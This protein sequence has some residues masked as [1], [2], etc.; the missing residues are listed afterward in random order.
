M[1]GK[2]VRRKK[3]NINNHNI[4]LFDYLITLNLDVINSVL[5]AIKVYKGNISSFICS[6]IDIYNIIHI[7]IL[8]MYYEISTVLK[9]ILIQNKLCVKL[10]IYK[11]I[12]TNS[13]WKIKYEDVVYNCILFSHF[14][15][16][17]N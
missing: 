3:N 11:I 5:Q 6:F 1:R 7:Y 9:K 10:N 14:V 2:I 12:I 8:F 13:H 4:N 16:Y 17:F 15:K